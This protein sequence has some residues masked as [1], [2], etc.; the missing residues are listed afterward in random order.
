MFYSIDNITGDE[1]GVFPQ[2]SCI[3]QTLAHSIQFD[4]FAA[5]IP[6]LVFEIEKRAKVTDVLSQA[7]IS[8]HGMLISERFKTLMENFRIMNHVFYPAVV[9]T[10]TADLQYYWIH[11]AD[12]SFV[13]KI[14]YTKSIFYWTRSTM[15]KGV[16]EL[17]SFDDYLG[18]KEKNGHLWGVD[19]DKIVL[20]K[21]FDM[22]LDMFGC[23]PFDMGIYVS[24]RLKNAILS[25]E[26]SGLELK[27]AINIAW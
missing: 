8:A 21:N 10:R 12:D 1:T 23:L 19:I 27:E 22:T 18:Q 9:K 14:D 6:E 13:N 20:N 11:L 24:E 2:V 17:S 16:I 3:S 4:E 26:I 7:A 15:R 25:M 5:K